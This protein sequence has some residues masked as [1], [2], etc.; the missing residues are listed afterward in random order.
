MP[1]A[2]RRPRAGRACALG[3]E[4]RWLG[5]HGRRGG[6]TW[7][8]TASCRKVIQVNRAALGEGRL[9]W[10]ALGVSQRVYQPRVCMCACA[11]NACVAWQLGLQPTAH[12][13]S[14]VP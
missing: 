4:R 13:A 12:L 3:E 6:A 14:S 8:R 2:Q 1:P 11:W 9:E 5:L 7:C 10:Y